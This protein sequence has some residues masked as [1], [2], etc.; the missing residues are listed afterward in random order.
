VDEWECNWEIESNLAQYLPINTRKKAAAI[1][2]GSSRTVPK[3]L[4]TQETQQ[5][6]NRQNNDMEIELMTYM[7]GCPG[8]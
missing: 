8:T 4:K 1:R 7:H 6:L 3:S 2:T 5:A